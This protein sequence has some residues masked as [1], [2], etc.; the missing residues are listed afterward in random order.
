MKCR[1]D[2]KPVEH[3]F[4]DLGFSP[5]SNSYLSEAQLVEPEAQY[6]L[7]L[8]VSERTWLVQI[9]EMKKADE[10]FNESYA[11]YS[12]FSKSWLEHAR[13]YVEMIASRL[14]LG[15]N[16]FVI[17]IASNDGYLLKNFLP[18]GIPVLGVEP[19]GG[20]AKEA[21][22]L[23]IPCAVEFFTEEFGHRLRS[24]GRQADLIA[25]N[26]VFAHVPNVNDFIRGLKAA[27]KPNGT[28]TLEF[29]HLME[30]IEY[31]QYDTI[32]HEHFSYFSLY[33]AQ[34]IFKHHGM[35][36]Y[37]VERLKTHGGSLR[38]Y[39]R[40]EA[41]KSNPVSSRVAE[42]LALEEQKG[43]RT[44]DYYLTF[45][46]RVR[47]HKLEIVKFIAEEKLKGKTFAAYGAAAK[48]NTLLNYC[49]ITYPVIDFVVDA[50]PHKQGLYMP[51]NHIPIVPEAR[52]RESRPDYVIILPWN[53]KDE[54]M[55]Q[56]AYVREW[57]AR[58]VVPIPRLDVL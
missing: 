2:G 43:M 29:P 51:G 9:G 38:I 37:D 3:V 8:Y 13:K 4:V 45:A 50:S 22:K 46:K 39:V 54:I 52:L 20:P 23:G 32:Y 6:P 26:N 41:D 47:Q 11:Y 48:G 33:T 53:L 15:K 7:K 58:F 24:E 28:V 25:G 42:L 40:H 1:F 14:K 21:A 31:N 44:L 19:S 49:G 10:I 27:L 34:E 12:S 55:Q 57:G 18:L 5:P 30:L 36:V 17:E 56:I 35:C 16:S